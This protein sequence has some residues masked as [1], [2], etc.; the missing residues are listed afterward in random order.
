MKYK[1]G[2]FI[3]FLVLVSLFYTWYMANVP[4]PLNWEDTYSPEGKNPYDTY[5]TYHSLPALFPA[6]KIVFSRHTIKEQVEDLPEGKPVNYLFVNRTF[7]VNPSERKSLFDFVEKGN[8]VFIAA[9]TIESSFLDALNLV[10]EYDYSKSKHVF[11][12]T[13]V[14]DSMYRFSGRDGC[15]VLDS[16]FQ[17]VVLGKL[18]KGECPDFVAVSQGKGYFYLNL[19]PRAFTNYHVLD[20]AGEG[21]FYRALSYLP[22]QAGIVV[23]D[24]YK[25]LG[26]KGEHSLFRVIL[27]YP[28]LRWA[29]YLF[30]MGALIWVT[31]SVR[32]EQRPIPV[33][34]PREN[35]MLDFV[36]SVSSLYYKQKD[37]YQIAEKR[38]EFFLER[39]R[40][41]YKIRTD[42]LDAGFIRILA[43]RSGI[44]E[45]QVE[46]LVNMIHSIRTSRNVDVEK[47]RELVKATERFLYFGV[48]KK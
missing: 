12:C 41:Y 13:G 27:E 11:T 47:L 33:V 42:E 9:E 22:E 21:Y 15:F 23:W 38:I 3:G 39:I 7:T 5:I 36:A 8:F 10:Q 46:H 31:F 29:F 37:H 14:S 16:A 2:I 43:E 32:R 17:G 40:S 30:L 44:A 34:L 6:S 25:T 28:A 45:S 19:N 20:S 48:N 26:R 4:Q 18:D 24:A 35:K 1:S